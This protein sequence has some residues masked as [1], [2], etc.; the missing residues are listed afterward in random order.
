MSGFFTGSVF[1]ANIAKQNAERDAKDA[2][3]RARN[4]AD[5]KD[6]KWMDYAAAL[7]SSVDARKMTEAEL[8]AELQ[9]IDPSNP[10]A[11]KDNVEAIDTAHYKSLR[12]TPEKMDA[13]S[14]RIVRERDEY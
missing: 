10:L 9:K 6:Q 4:A 13:L 14:K 5:K 7:R 3:A 8:I 12:D 11:D 1:G 2:A